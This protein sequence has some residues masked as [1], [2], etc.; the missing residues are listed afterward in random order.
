MGAAAVLA[1][2]LAGCGGGATPP[3]PAAA[4]A[5][6]SPTAVPPTA[7]PPTAVPPTAVPA[8]PTTVPPTPVP[9][10]PVPTLVHRAPVATPV[11]VRP[12]AASTSAVSISNYAFVPATLHLSVGSKVTWTN[13]DPSNHT[14]TAKNGAFD[15]SDLQRGQSFT[16]TFSKA[17][18]YAYYCRVHP[19]MT[20]TIVV[21]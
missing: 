17:G 4:T 18:T 9:A 14:V 20:G 11:P 2:A 8:T 19:F 21:Q 10:T 3:P 12:A 6:P 13:K 5:A 15:S 16:F 1:L 7:V